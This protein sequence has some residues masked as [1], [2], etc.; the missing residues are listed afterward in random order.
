MS[1]QDKKTRDGWRETIER[2]IRAARGYRHFSGGTG[3]HEARVARLQRA[4]DQTDAVLV[5]AGAGLSTAE[6]EGRSVCID[7]DIA[8]VQGELL[9]ATHD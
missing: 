8:V 4:L 5:G 6:I 2:G 7:A 3:T 1:I 9:E